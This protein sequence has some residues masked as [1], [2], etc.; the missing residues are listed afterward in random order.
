MTRTKNLLI[1]GFLLLFTVLPLAG[2]ASNFLDKANEGGLNTIGA[3][4]Y[5]VTGEPRSLGSIVAGIIK[6][7]LGLLGIIFVVLLIIAGFRYMTAAGNEDKVHEAV[8]QIRNAIIGLVIV[9]CAYA[10]TA[11]ITNQLVTIVK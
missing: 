11:F 4:A 1:T 5:E 7:A 6:V 9:V 8:K 10:V 2:Q 3:K